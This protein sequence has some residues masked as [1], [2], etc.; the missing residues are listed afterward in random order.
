MK[1][2]KTASFLHNCFPLIAFNLIFGVLI[3]IVEVV[4]RLFG[5]NSNP[6]SYIHKLKN[7]FR[8]TIFVTCFYLIFNEELLLLILQYSNL[9]FSTARNIISFILCLI[10]TVHFIILVG[11]LIRVTFDPNDNVRTKSSK[12]SMIFTG[13]KHEDVSYFAKYFVL[14]K[15]AFRA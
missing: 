14:L 13:L 3:L 7:N 6:N 15:L 11:F 2:G 1:S 9:D 8:W 10:F 4:F 12:Y 5:A